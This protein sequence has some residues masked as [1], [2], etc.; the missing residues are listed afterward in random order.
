MVR[1]FAALPSV[2]QVKASDHT[3]Q[4]VVQG[5]VDPVVKKAANYPVLTMTSHEPTLEEAFLTYYRGSGDGDRGSGTE[6]AASDWR[7][8][9]G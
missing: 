6:S 9:T 4:F 2:S 7:P 1:A 3:L 5:D 8:P